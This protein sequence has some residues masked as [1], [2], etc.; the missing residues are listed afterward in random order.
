M[1]QRASVSKRHLTFLFT[2]HSQLV[3]AA[4]ASQLEHVIAATRIAAS[5]IVA[6]RIAETRITLHYS[7]Q[8]SHRCELQATRIIAVRR[9]LRI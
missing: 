5:I 9:G 8:D 6:S 3:A 1:C 2:L 4:R 7:V